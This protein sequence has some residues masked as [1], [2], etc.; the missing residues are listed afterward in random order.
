MMLSSWRG[1]LAVALMAALP[2]DV[3]SA[4]LTIGFAGTDN[5]KFGAPLSKIRVRLELPIQK[6]DQ[7]PRGRSFYAY[8]END[9]RY[10]LMFIEDGLVRIDVMQPGLRTADGV[11]VGD[12]VSKVRE[13]YGQAIKDELDA[14]DD[15]ERYLTMSSSDGKF[16]IRFMTRDGRV[17]AIISGTEKSVQYVEGCL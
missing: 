2:L 5:I 3:M 9:K 15:G 8:P 14:Y 1:V 16:S 7:D 13:I 12:P 17:S 6:F 4:D 10:S 11:E